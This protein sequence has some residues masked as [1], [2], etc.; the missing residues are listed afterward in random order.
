MDSNNEMFK[1]VDECMGSV[2]LLDV[3]GDDSTPAQ[4]ARVSY[5]KDLEDRTQEEDNKLSKY[6][7][8]NKHFSPFEMVNYKFRIKC[9]IFVMRQWVR[10]RI[11]S[12]NEKSGRYTKFE[13]EEVFIP[14]EYRISGTYSKQGSVEPTMEF[15]NEYNSSRTQ[16]ERTIESVE[17]WNHSAHNMV[18]QAWDKAYM[19]YTELLSLGVCKEQARMVLPLNTYTEFIWQ[20]NFRSLDNFLKLRLHS[21]A[22]KEIRDY[23]KA[24]LELTKT[25]TPYLMSLVEDQISK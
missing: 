15:I 6:L 11:A 9:P 1:Q 14:T 22:Q 23:A 10:H 18:K 13:G 3:M 25:K 17:K 19:Y 12:I 4:C 5:N 20:I 2:T 24:I 7:Y 16:A 8:K 21:H